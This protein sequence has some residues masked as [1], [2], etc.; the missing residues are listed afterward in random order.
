[1][2]PRPY[3]HA[4]TEELG[5]LA[6]A[7][8]SSADGLA[9]LLWELGFRTSNAAVALAERL[10][11]RHAD[12]LAEQRATQADDLALMVRD[13]LAR[14]L[15][16]LVGPPRPTQAPPAT[17]FPPARRSSPATG[18]GVI[19]R[20][21]VRVD[22]TGGHFTELWQFRNLFKI[23]AAAANEPTGGS[24]VFDFAD[25]EFLS[26][27]AVALLGGLVRWL[28]HRSVARSYVRPRKAA[29]WAN[30]ERNGLA[31]L[32]ADRVGRDTG[33]AIPYREDLKENRA[34]IMDY[35][36]VRWLGR[37]DWLRVSEPLRHV[38]VGRVWEIYANAFEHARSPIG[39]FSCGQHYPKLGLLDLTV[40]DWGVGIPDNVRRFLRRPSMKAT[41]AL[42]WAFT[43]G[44]S[45]SQKG[46]ARGLGLDFLK[47]FV[48]LNKGHLKVFSD[49]GYAVVDVTGAHFE[50]W[51]ARFNGTLVNISLRCDESY[52]VL[53]HEQGKGFV[54]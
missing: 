28:Q 30:L 40:V 36:K 37:Q 26:H 32:F 10:R 14:R 34:G 46:M 12:L 35:L 2:S 54:F 20:K 53:A 5:Q 13:A 3:S 42:A 8:W 24:V 52:Y 9:P 44:Q 48:T 33:N 23:V 11:K 50:H 27:N 47:E 19:Q 39:V 15:S 31:G 7:F 45:T 43:P 21:P 17:A 6:K 41:E 29:V 25:C 4:S 16:R 1:M 22:L 51:D 49:D 18:S 38:I